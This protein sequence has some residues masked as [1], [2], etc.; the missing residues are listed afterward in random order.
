M[1]GDSNYFS[2]DFKSLINMMLQY[3]PENRGNIVD[4]LNHKY[5]HKDNMGTRELVENE[6]TKRRKRMDK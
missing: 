6:F 1:K 4:I 3:L 2:E 5:L